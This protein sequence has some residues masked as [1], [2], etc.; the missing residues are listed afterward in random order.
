MTHGEEIAR[1]GLHPPTQ[2]DALLREADVRDQIASI[3]RSR[4]RIVIGWTTLLVIAGVTLFQAPAQ[5][6]VLPL[7]PFLMFKRAMLK[8]EKLGSRKSALLDSL[9]AVRRLKS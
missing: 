9:G 7:L 1:T 6:A 5:F 2:A 3:D 8:Y 4:S